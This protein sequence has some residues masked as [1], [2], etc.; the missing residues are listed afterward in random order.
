MLSVK[1]SMNEYHHVNK[2]AEWSILTVKSMEG[3]KYGETA[4][5]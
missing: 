2:L 4:C 3:N 1:I 5:P